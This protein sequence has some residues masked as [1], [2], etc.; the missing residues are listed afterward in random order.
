VVFQSILQ[1]EIIPIATI[2]EIQKLFNISDLMTSS[3]H[4][5]SN[6]G[7]D[8]KIFEEKLFFVTI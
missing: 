5:F 6:N 2:G 1:G 3:A 4:I 7:V 8:G